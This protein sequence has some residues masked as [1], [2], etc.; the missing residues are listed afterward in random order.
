MS[1]VQGLRDL[2]GAL[3]G[4]T[5]ATIRFALQAREIIQLWRDLCARLFF[6]QLNNAF[7]A[8]A[9][10]LNGL[11]DFAMPESGRSSVLVPKRPV[12]GI[13]SLLGIRQ[14]QLETCEQSPRSL[15][16]ALFFVER[17][18]EPTPWIFACS[19]AEC[20]DNLIQLAGLEFLN[21]ALAIDDN[22]QR[23]RL[24]SSERSDSA[25][26]SATES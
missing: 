9:F 3:R 7:F 24:Y 2:Q 1:F 5:E 21:L 22:C 11:G 20:A 26:T 13:K 25:A 10:A 19:C 4:E 18:V 16:L 15:D 6:L 14:I 8:G 12:G 23:R 17:F